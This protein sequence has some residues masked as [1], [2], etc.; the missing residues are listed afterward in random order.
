MAVAYIRDIPL[1]P[2]RFN[3]EA[4]RSRLLQLL[5]KQEKLNAAEVKAAQDAAKQLVSHSLRRTEEE[6]R[7]TQD[8]LFRYID[9]KTLV[10][11]DYAAGFGNRDRQA[12]LIKSALSVP[13]LKHLQKLL[14]GNHQQQPTHGRYRSRTNAKLIR[15][16]TRRG[17]RHARPEPSWYDRIFKDS[18]P[19]DEVSIGDVY[20]SVKDG[21]PQLAKATLKDTDLSAYFEKMGLNPDNDDDDDDDDD[22]ESENESELNNILDA[23]KSALAKPV[24]NA[25][26]QFIESASEPS[27]DESGKKSVRFADDVH[28]DFN[29]I[30]NLEGEKELKDALNAI[31]H[32]VSSRKRKSFDGLVTYVLDRLYAQQ[33]DQLAADEEA[34]WLT[35]SI[36]L[37]QELK[38]DENLATLAKHLL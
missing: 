5:Q 21:L 27:E 23:A 12:F 8:R 35:A 28:I 34:A 20:K 2:V 22:T 29:G 16:P 26:K 37:L 13:E 4:D 36:A 6:K 3:G 38:H 31:R 1:L 14:N 11:V 10:H 18:E 17:A 33:E 19:E 24:K 9:E 7:K 32:S 15:P 25:V 30:R